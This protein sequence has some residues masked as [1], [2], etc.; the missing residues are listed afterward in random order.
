MAKMRQKRG[1]A[2]S[3]GLESDLEG[4]L[5]MYDQ[6]LKFLSENIKSNKG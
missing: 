3:M 6:L 2:M 4:N 5:S 1:I